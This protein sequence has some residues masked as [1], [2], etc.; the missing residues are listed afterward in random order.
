[1]SLAAAPL[2]QPGLPSAAASLGL[3]IALMLTAGSC[4]D[5]LQ[6][7]PLSRSPEP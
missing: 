4:S 2:K 5:A 6:L 3:I 7:C 1:M